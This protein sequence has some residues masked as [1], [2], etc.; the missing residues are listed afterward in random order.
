MSKPAAEELQRL[1]HVR[2]HRTQRYIH[3]LGYLLVFHV[4]QIAEL[5]YFFTFVWQFVDGIMNGMV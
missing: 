2:F 5:K 1:I 4:V 3:N